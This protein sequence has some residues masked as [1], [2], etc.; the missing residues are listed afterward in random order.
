MK[1]LIGSLLLTTAAVLGVAP[2]AGAEEK[3]AEKKVDTRVF[4]LR[5]YTAEAGKMDALKA[6]FRDHTV[7]LFEKH[8][9]TN[10]GY[11]TELTPKGEEKLYYVLAYPSKEAADKSWA[12]FRADPDWIKAKNASEKDGPLVKKVESV[13]L[14]PTDFSGIK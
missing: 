12:A 10:V 3:P 2:R 1:T 5:I 11:W 4:E 6:R 14:K 9:M 7:K 8:G 13:Y